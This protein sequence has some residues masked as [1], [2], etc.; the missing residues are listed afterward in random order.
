MIIYLGFRY[1]GDYTRLKNRS[2]FLILVVFTMITFKVSQTTIKDTVDPQF[3]HSS[4]DF[5]IWCVFTIYL[6]TNLDTL[7][8]VSYELLP[9]QFTWL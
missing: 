7:G 2:T 1:I 6:D 9:S 8:M 5:E 4:C 3:L